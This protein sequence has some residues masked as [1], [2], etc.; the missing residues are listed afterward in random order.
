M[1]K[2]A[3]GFDCAGLQTSYDFAKK[4]LDKEVHSGM[5]RG[6]HIT[7]VYIPANVC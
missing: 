7:N 5:G 1:W 3:P 6:I 4:I 2:A